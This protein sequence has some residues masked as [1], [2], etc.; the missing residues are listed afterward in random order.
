MWS[1][2]WWAT[3]LSG[4]FGVTGLLHVARVVVPVPLSIAG[5]DV[6]RA[7]TAIAGMICLGL[8]AGLLWVEVLRERRRRA[9]AGSPQAPKCAHK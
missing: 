7:V 1:R 2:C 3:W 9:A 6:P 8:S 5:Y 4:F